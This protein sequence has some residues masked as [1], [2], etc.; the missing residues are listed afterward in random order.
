MQAT[1]GPKQHRREYPVG[2]TLIELLV[3]IAIIAILA[4]MLLPALSKAKQ[5]ATQAACLSNMKQL[6]LGW[7][8]Y[9]DDNSD[10]VVNLSTYINGAQYGVPW[11]TD[12]SNGELSPAAVTTTEDSWINSIRQGYK[13]P[14]PTTDGPLWRYAP[15][16]DIMHC[17]GDKHY[18]MPYK[19]GGGGPFCYDSYSG[20]VNL[21]GEGHVPTCIYKRTGVGHPSAKYIW[22]ESTDGRGENIGS[23]EMT[24]SGTIADGFAG[25]AFEDAEDG[26]AAYH[27]SS[28][29]FN[30]CDGHAETHKWMDGRTLAFANNMNGTGTLPPS[31]VD[32]V[33]VALHTAGTQNP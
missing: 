26:P 13:K 7:M 18:L 12:I 22:I 1:L 16:P 28:A 29:D 9:A 21:N 27:G 3:V 5:K 11:R 23:W 24:I 17:P 10:L 25:S 32:S 31:N 6:A 30:F 19:A 8:M 4:A 2:F 20:S 15:N 14:Q 33:W